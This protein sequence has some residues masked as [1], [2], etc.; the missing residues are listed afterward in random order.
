MRQLYIKCTLFVLLKVKS[1]CIIM[2]TSKLV[3]LFVL[4]FVNGLFFTNGFSQ[5]SWHK[6]TDFNNANS[7]VWM[8]TGFNDKNYVI[9]AD[10]WIYY[11]DADANQWIPFQ[12]VPTFYNV[13]SIKGSTVTN[14]VFCLTSSS[15]IA[16]TDNYGATWQSNNLT[17]GGGTSGFGALILAYGLKD[18]RVLVSTIGPSSG[19]IQNNLFLSTN[20][21]STFSE[22]TDIPFYPTDFHFLTDT[23]IISNTSDGIYLTTNLNVTPWTQLAFDGLQV[24]DMVVNGSAMY[25]SVLQISGDGKVYKSLDEGV[26]WIELSGIPVNEGV[27]KLTFDAVNNRVFVTSTSGIH[28]YSGSS[29][30]TLSSNA[31]AHEIGITANQS[32]LFCGIQVEGIHKIN[33]STLS[34]EKVNNGLNIVPDFM[35][36]SADDQIYTASNRTAFLSQYNLGT[37][38]WNSHTLFDSINSTNIVSMGKNS[39]GQCVVGGLHYIAKTNSSGSSITM[40]ANDYTA[41]L[42]PIYDILAPFKMFVGNNGSI[43]TIQHASQNY[44][45]Y[46]P[47]MGTTWAVLFETIMGVSPGLLTMD[48][49]CSGTSSHFILGMSNTT[50]Q[51]IVITS[52]DEGATWTTVPNPNGDLVR[53]IFIDKFNTLYA[54]TTTNL[55]SWDAL[56]STWFE[57]NIDLGVGVSNKVIEV[58]FNSANKPHVLIRTTTTPFAEEGIYVPNSTDDGF[59]HVQFPVVG[60]QTVPLK[61]LSFTTSDILIATSNFQLRNFPLEGIYYYYENSILSTNTFN[62]ENVSVVYPNP[63]T[64]LITLSLPELCNGNVQIIDLNGRVFTAAMIN[65]QV[66]VSTLSTGFYFVRYENNGEQFNAKFSVVP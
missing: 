7:G 17:G 23:K 48:K 54:A 36:L 4:L 56:T 5:Q 18:T 35:V 57:L 13:G 52:S 19:P 38:H 27:S 20:N 64:N 51:N 58:A 39:D 25:A 41:P 8:G 33:S 40:I 24:T 11:S 30:S 6:L 66:D 21:G 46:S 59:I 60:G 32:V 29:W 14:R 61:N 47:D 43:S 9:T 53:N 63:A 42:A 22:L 12:N 10:R 44:V 28:V 3:A 49:V 50:A 16:Y 2:K 65:N 45:D 34:V 37:H 55:Y 26:T 31:H 15:G 1:H 62:E